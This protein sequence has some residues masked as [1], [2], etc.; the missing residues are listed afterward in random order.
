MGSGRQAN[1]INVFTLCLFFIF[2]TTF[3][4]A[5][6]KVIK[7]IKVK[8]KYTISNK[9]VKTPRLI[10]NTCFLIY[11]ICDFVSVF[12][13]SCYF[14]PVLPIWQ[15]RRTDDIISP[16][17]MFSDFLK[18]WG[19]SP[20]PKTHRRQDLPSSLLKIRFVMATLTASF[21]IFEKWKQCYQT[22]KIIVRTTFLSRSGV[23]GL[24][25]ERKNSNS[26]I[27]MN[28]YLIQQKQGNSLLTCSGSGN[29]NPRA[30]FLSD[31]EIGE[32]WETQLN[33]K[34]KKP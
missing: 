23:S 33:V 32:S 6:L 24:I 22:L 21:I 8:N 7:C 4:V 2:H 31:V 27:W 13:F 34:E 30:S 3:S 29:L 28:F 16:F 26:E 15:L 9:I 25:K 20:F 1:C 14:L 11:I 19:M 17:Q 18:S 5:F 12:N 10:T